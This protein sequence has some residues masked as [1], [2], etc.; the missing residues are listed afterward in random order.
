MYE[1]GWIGDENMYDIMEM[2]GSAQVWVVDSI[3]GH[4][5]AIDGLGGHHRR[6]HINGSQLHTGK[7]MY[8]V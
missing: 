2:C 3:Y 6:L 1:Y 5:C 7:T 8:A 4:A